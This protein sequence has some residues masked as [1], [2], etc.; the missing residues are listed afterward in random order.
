MLKALRRRLPGESTIYLGDTARVPYGTKSAEVVTRY[1]LMNARLLARNDIKLLVVAC[2]TSSAVAL[3][4][5]QEQLAIPVIGV[6]EPGA[7]VAAK[8]SRSGR[9]G[10]IGTPG[11][12]DSGAYQ[13]A[14]ARFRPGAT[15]LAQACPLFVPLAEEGWTTGDVPRGVAKHYLREIAES[16]IDTLVLGCTHYPLLRDTISAAVEDRLTLVDS[17]EATAEEVAVLL[18]AEDLFR[19]GG[20]AEHRYLVTD[21]PLLFARVGSRFLGEPIINAER[22]DVL[23]EE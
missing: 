12:I 7:K 20:P 11:T 5:M 2:N 16:D 14:I 9:I 1:S 3:P 8:V 13:K 21:T 10:V 6:I 23:F 22:V 17:A 15:V 18:M 19:N 4:R